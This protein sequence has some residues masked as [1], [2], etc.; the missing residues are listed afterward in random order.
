MQIWVDGDACP[1]MVKQILF[2]ACERTQ[3][4]LIFVANHISNVPRSLHISVVIVASGFDEADKYITDNAKA[5]DLVITADIPLAANVVANGC[6]ALNPR[7]QLYTDANIKQQLAV[8][9]LMANL[10][11]QMLISGGPATLNK[12]DTQVFARE[13]DKILTRYQISNKE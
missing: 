4:K 5:C 13:L 9:N 7:G 1:A 2:R 10:R 11:D 8:R 3:I 12:N 6:I